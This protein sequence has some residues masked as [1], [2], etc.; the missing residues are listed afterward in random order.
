MV[1]IRTLGATLCLGLGATALRF[2][3]T[4]PRPSPN[5]PLGM[6]A[7]RN[8]NL[9][10]K[11]YAPCG[12]GAEFWEKG[13]DHAALLAKDTE[14]CKTP[15]GSGKTP[16]FLGQNHN[17]CIPFERVN[18]PSKN[19]EGSWCYVYSEC[20]ENGGKQVSDFAAWKPC[21]E[22]D[23]QM[24][25]LEPDELFAVAQ[26]GNQSIVDMALRVYSWEEVK[27]VFEVAN[28]GAVELAAESD[29][30]VVTANY[31][32]K[33]SGGRITVRGVTWEVDAKSNTGRCIKN[34]P[35]LKQ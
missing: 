6:C 15:Q 11:K 23:A 3:E 26:K 28:T 33:K 22:E 17:L 12:K 34:C 5:P 21:K 8:W 25:D 31:V 29:S 16:F 13:V 2:D 4:K 7:C 35:P 1:A 27:D 19:I 18:G 30:A 14:L 9:V 24:Q 32:R 10:Y 20:V